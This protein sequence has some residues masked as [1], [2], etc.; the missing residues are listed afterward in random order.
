MA[1]SGHGGQPLLLRHGLWWDEEAANTAASP[2]ATP[3]SASGM[4]VTSASSEEKDISKSAPAD[5]TTRDS[6]GAPAGG[7]SG[8]AVHI[9]HEQIG[10]GLQK[11]LG[12]GLGGMR[13][14]IPL[15]KFGY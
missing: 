12:L 8:K 9:L 14:S 2:S 11:D 7:A 1:S 15:C 4:A 13:R 3:G 10:A 5:G 6:A